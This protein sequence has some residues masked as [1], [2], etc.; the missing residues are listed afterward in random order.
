MS[1]PGT[2]ASGLAG[3]VALDP[4]TLVNADDE[5]E[6]SDRKRRWRFCGAAAAL[7]VAACSLAIPGG[8]VP[9]IE[10]RWV[11]T[12][13][14][15]SIGMDELIN[16][17]QGL[18]PNVAAA[19]APAA[20]AGTV[21]SEDA[22]NA[23]A[24]DS[25]AFPNVSATMESKDD[26]VVVNVPRTTL[27]CSVRDLCPDCSEGPQTRPAFKLARRDTF[28][29]PD[30]SD[31][32]VKSVNVTAG[33]VEISLEPDLD[34]VPLKQGEFE[35]EIRSVG[36]TEVLAEFSLD[37]DLV[38][39]TPVSYKH[40]FAR[41]PAT[42]VGGIELVVTVDAPAGSDIVNV[43]LSK[44]IRVAAEVEDLTVSAAV[45]LI[46]KPIEI[47]PQPIDVDDDTVSEIVDRVTG[48]TTVTI[49][50]TNPLPIEMQGTIDLG[51][52]VPLTA[53]EQSVAVASGT[54]DEPKT[55]TKTLTITRE[56]LQAFLERGQ[57]SFSGN[58]ATGGV[59]TLD[60]DQ[61]IRVRITVDVSLVTEPEGT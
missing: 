39:G 32:S 57:F 19:H 21:R 4:E 43:D 61:E 11:L 23:E 42:V 33:T 22:A 38:G 55:T 34:F 49:T 8:D 9:K 2:A 52:G 7:V 45:V 13:L 50:L 53:A 56:E 47:D 31:L 10:Q 59:V 60:T 48:T 29:L 26:H 24:A 25:C 27:E 1:G 36:S 46:D 16:P 51:D 37:R 14:D 12:P 58:A 6:M 20:F 15:V 41:N 35:I 17:N 54:P 30:S 18:L 40:D 5:P 44:K 3:Q 28:P